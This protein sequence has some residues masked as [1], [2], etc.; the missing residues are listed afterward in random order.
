[1]YADFKVII[2]KA[3]SLDMKIPL[4][5]QPGQNGRTL[6]AIGVEGFEMDLDTDEVEI[7][8]SGSILADMADA[9]I[10]IMKD[11]IIW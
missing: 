5:T 4:K 3:A 6:L 11:V 1:V 7:E 9:F 2:N 10:W 8:L